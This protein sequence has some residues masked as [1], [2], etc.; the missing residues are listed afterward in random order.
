[1]YRVGVS[2]RMVYGVCMLHSVYKCITRYNISC[3]LM[4]MDRHQLLLESLVILSP[5]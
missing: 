1:M 4:P 2:A 3:Q 5:R